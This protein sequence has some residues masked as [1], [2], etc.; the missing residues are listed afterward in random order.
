M[1]DPRRRQL[2]RQARRGLRSRRRPWAG[3]CWPTRSR[4]TPTESCSSR[5]PTRS[6]SGPTSSLVEGRDFSPEQLDRFAGSCGGAYDPRRRRA[7]LNACPGLALVHDYL[8]V[9]RGAERTFAAITDIWPEAPIATLLYDEAG[10]QAGSR[11]DGHHVAAGAPGRPPGGTSADS[12]RSTRPRRGSCRSTASTASCPAAARSRTACGL[13][14]GGTRLLLPLAVPLR[15]ARAG[16]RAAEVPPPLRPALSARAAAPPRRSTAA[17]RGGST[18]TWPT[19]RSPASGSAGSGAGTPRSCIRPWTSSASPSESPPTT[20]C[21]S[22]ELVRH[23]RPE[24]AIEAALAAGRRIKLVGAGPSSG[25]SR[26]RSAGRPSSSGSVGDEELARLYA[27]AAGA[28]GAQ[29]RGVR[30]RRRGGAGGRAAGGGSG[31]RGAARDRRPGAH[32]AARG[33]RRPRRARAGAGRGPTRVRPARHPGAR[34]AVL[35]AR[36]F[37]P[38]SARSSKPR[39]RTHLEGT[40]RR[41]TIGAPSRSTRIRRGLPIGAAPCPRRPG[42]SAAPAT[43]AVRAPPRAGPAPA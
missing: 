29:R 34:R 28:R 15:L 31:R 8:L 37:R 7:S 1:H 24:L 10:T 5:R 9:L 19:P 33:A 43:P 30:H 6:G 18:S 40:V 21:S 36:R 11:Q 38:A 32:G 23:K 22:G 3:C 27:G 12:C 4:R 20:C 26:A 13:R 39:A 42:R 16:A 14:R 35:A 41:S 25:G 17:P 2:V